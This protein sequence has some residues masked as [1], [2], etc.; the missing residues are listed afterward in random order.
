M[1]AYLHLAFNQWLQRVT[2]ALQHETVRLRDA[3]ESARD[4][5]HKRVVQTAGALKHSAASCAASKNG[6]IPIAASVEVDF[7]G[8]F[9]GVANDHE[10]IAGL[11][12]PEDAVAF[13][14]FAPIEQRFIAGQIFGRR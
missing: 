9:V 6:N 13:S 2:I 12:K 8:R 14:G 3:L 7:D 1:S 11:P 4:S 5:Q 10:I